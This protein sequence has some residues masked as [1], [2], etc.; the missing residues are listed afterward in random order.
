MKDQSYPLWISI[1]LENTQNMRL[2]P[3]Q[4]EPPVITVHVI[5]RRPFVLTEAQ[6]FRFQML[7]L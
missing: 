5:S 1:L 6:P 7:L 4:Y 2:F 3:P